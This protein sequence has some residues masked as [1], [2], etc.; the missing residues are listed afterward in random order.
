MPLDFLISPPK[1]MHDVGKKYSVK[2]LIR[3]AALQKDHGYYPYSRL[4]V[5]CVIQSYTPHGWR[6]AVGAN[7][8][9]ASYGLTVCAERIAVWQARYHGIAQYAEVLVICSNTDPP[10][11]PC[12]ACRQVMV[13]LLPANC[14]VISVNSQGGQRKWRVGELLPF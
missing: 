13:E 6:R 10:A 3:I 11:S 4:A 14:K 8:E 12:G 5:G 1:K 2:E 9:N 7:M